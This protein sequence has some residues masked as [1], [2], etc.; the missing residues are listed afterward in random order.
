MEYLT[1]IDYKSMGGLLDE[2]AFKR[3]AFMAQKEID[4]ETFNRVLNMSIIPKEIKMLI[5]ELIQIN[6]AGDISEE[7]VLSESV[8][9]WSKSY[10]ETDFNSLTERKLQLIHSYLSGINDDKLTPLLYRGIN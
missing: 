3:Y 1:Y 4:R 2:T 5:F 9:S 6:S 7:R 8:G 10:A